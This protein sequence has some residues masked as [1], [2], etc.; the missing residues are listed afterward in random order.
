MGLFLADSTAIGW[1]DL[2]SVWSVITAQINLTQILLI[3]GG[4]VGAAIVLVFAW[5]GLRK[6][7]RILMSAAKGGKLKV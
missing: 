7:I 3:L 2:S 1:T 4:A 5:W 6:A